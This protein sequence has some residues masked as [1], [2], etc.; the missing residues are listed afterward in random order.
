M[1]EI[2][3]QAHKRGLKIY[4]GTLTPFN[5]YDAGNY[6]TEEGERTRQEVNRWIRS[7]RVFDGVIDFDRVLADPKNP[8]KLL[9]E[10]DSGDALHPNDLG[11]KAMAESI[12]L[13]L[14]KKPL[15]KVCGK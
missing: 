9:A 11:L 4:V 12:D 2:A 6:Y 3:K 13:S 7:N 10:F 8:E 14:F 1:Q 15:N 5:A